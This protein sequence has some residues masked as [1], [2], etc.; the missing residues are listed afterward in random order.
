M[1]RLDAIDALHQIRDELEVVWL[2]LG[3]TADQGGDDSDERTRPMVGVRMVG[4]ERAQ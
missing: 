2:A 4:G 1:T 3:N